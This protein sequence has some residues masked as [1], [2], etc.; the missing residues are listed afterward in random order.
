MLPALIAR[1]LECSEVGRVIVTLNIPEDFPL[2]EDGRVVVIRNAAAKGFG[3]NHNAA[4][5]SLEM[6]SQ[7]LYFCPLNPDIR[8]V[9]NPFPVLLAEMNANGAGVGVPLVINDEG[10]VE[11]SLRRF[12]SLRM[13]LT[14]AM[15]GADGSYHVRKGQA[16]FCPEWAAGMFMLFRREA[17]AS[18]GGF[19]ERF[20][21]YY[22]DVDICV[23]AWKQGLR[24]VACPEVSVI[25]DARRDSRRKVRYMRWHLAS[26]AR[27]FWKHWWRL[28]SKC[29]R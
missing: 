7:W 6:D 22:E 18:L 26:M 3:E 12:P 27:Y 24:I 19:D 14:K 5:K 11:D 23:R 13:L 21:L 10:R 4:F 28:P 15:G 17:F 29:V 8:L 1:L 16:T 25:H 20:F 9:D 2:S